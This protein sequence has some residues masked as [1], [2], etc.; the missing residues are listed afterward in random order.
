M[1]ATEPNMNELIS[2][3]TSVSLKEKKPRKPPTKKCKKTPSSI[4]KTETFIETSPS[5][6]KLDKPDVAV[7]AEGDAPEELLG[8]LEHYEEDAYTILGSYFKDKEL[9]RL[10]RH[11]T[12]SMNHFIHYQMQATIDMFNPRTVS[13]EKDFNI[14][15]GE[16]NLKIIYNIKNLKFY[17]PQLYENNGSTKIMLPQEA[18]L[19]NFT[20]AS[21][22][23]VDLYLEINVRS[24]DTNELMVSEIMIP[25]IKFIDLPIML[26]SSNC[27]LQQYSQQNNFIPTGECPKDCG[28]YFIIKGSEKT[29]LGQERAAEN[30]IYIFQGKN[31]PKL[32][33]V[34][35]FKSVPD[36]KCISP[37]QMEML[38]SSKTSVYGHRMYVVIPRL[39]QKTHIELFVLFRALGVLSDKKICEYILLNVEDPKKTEMLKFLEASM[40]DANR[41]IKSEKTAQ[42]DA[43]KHIMTMVAYN[44]YATNTAVN[45]STTSTTTIKPN[46]NTLDEYKTHFANTVLKDILKY[47]R[48]FIDSKQISFYHYL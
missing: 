42:E 48:L 38:I 22:T 27:I 9:N 41:F 5:T 44:V 15:T 1:I 14:D 11:Q 10:T 20:Y 45:I 7:K 36:S 39:K 18:R 29:V 32:D 37:K 46:L 4:S 2:A 25:A 28:G 23:T 19:R 35:E 21:K 31:T 13:S 26:K 34:A 40:D 16:S 24:S 12:E 6:T 43:L 33:W 30:R 17:P 47:K 3:F 8:H